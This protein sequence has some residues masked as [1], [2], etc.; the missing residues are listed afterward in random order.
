MI[1][2]YSYLSMKVR[3]EL[4]TRLMNLVDGFHMEDLFYDSFT[5]RY[6]KIENAL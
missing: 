3:T 2:R 6:G 4:S 1:S 5:R